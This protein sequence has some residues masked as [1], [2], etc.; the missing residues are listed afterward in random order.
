MHEKFKNTYLQE[1]YSNHKDELILNFS[2]KNLSLSLIIRFA[3]GEMFY[4]I[5][6]AA[7]NSG[8]KS[9]TQFKALNN[10]MLNSVTCIQ[11]DR[12]ICLNFHDFTLW[13]KGFGRFG[14]VILTNSECNENLGVFRQNIKQ[15]LNWK[16]VKHDAGILQPDH[17]LKKFM[18]ICGPE[19][20]AYLRS[21]GFETLSEIDKLKLIEKTNE[22]LNHPSFCMDTSGNLPE[23]HF[24]SN[25]NCIPLGEGW[26]ALQQFA[27]EYLNKHRI[28]SMKEMLIRQT[29][30]RIKQLSKMAKDMNSQLEDIQ[31]RR[32]YKELG[33]IVLSYSHKIKPG[34][35][36]A[37]LP[38]F[39]T[40]NPI[41]IKLNPD[42]S[43][44]DNAAKFYAKA[45]NENLEVKKIE[46]NLAK[47]LLEL[48]KQ[49]NIL[50][51]ANQSE[52]FKFFKQVSNKASE[53]VEKPKPYKEFEYEGFVIWMGKS[54]KNN[55]EMLR[56]ASKNDLWL[57]TRNDS[58][59]HV[60]IRKKGVNFPENVIAY[61]AKIAAINSRSKSQ[62]LV[63]V[64]Y[65]E[66]KFVV[67]PKNAA[68]GEVKV[69]KEKTI[70]VRLDEA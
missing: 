42:K 67:K 31:N 32:S 6:D 30:T 51:Q 58:G 33:D 68:P 65:T 23:L 52:D 29:T 54:A 38:D 61:A 22:Y 56:L 57:H 46:E 64:I 11:F 20:N 4:E 36:E 18:S 47:T 53:Q 50:K 59:S 62:S 45:K 69:L 2:A 16:G 21:N 37:F 19:V 44:A 17:N 24:F 26:N 7:P 49:E 10:C 8:K 15:D 63:P 12:I 66:R 14:N 3:G 27:R 43:A 40:G 9:I 5:S 34:V 60:I 70:D 55:D 1:A 13:L 41:R 35:R 48:E 39:Y 28:F 25:D